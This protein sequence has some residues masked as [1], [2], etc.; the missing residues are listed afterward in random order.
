MEMQRR[1]FN[2]EFKLDAVKSVRER[3]VSVSQA[4]RDLDLHGNVLRKWVQEQVADPGSWSAEGRRPA[5]RHRRQPARPP[6]HG[7]SA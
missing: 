7:R 2:R 4:A 5:I 6:L 1:K 3:R